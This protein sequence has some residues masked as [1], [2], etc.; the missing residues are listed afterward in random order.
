MFRPA[1]GFSRFLRL[2]AAVG[3]AVL[4]A[5]CAHYRL[6]TGSE[7]KFATLFVAPVK[8]DT[9]IPQ[10]QAV[11]TTQLREAFLKDGRIALTNS[12]FEA[13][14]MLQVTLTG[15]EREIGV[16]RQDDTG[17]ARRVDVSLKAQV[18]LTDRRTGKPYFERRP[19]VAKRG[20]FSDGGLVPAEYQNLPLLAEQLAGETVHAVLDTW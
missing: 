7:I 15:I 17:L 2:T 18:T 9:Q 13:D 14:A 6:G 20:V 8:V 12:P 10:A 3:L 16:Y 1:I 4:A 5:G 11:V 19:V